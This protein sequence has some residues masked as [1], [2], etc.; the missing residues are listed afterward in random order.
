M[1]SSTTCVDNSSIDLYADQCASEA[2]GGSVTVGK[3]LPPVSW[4][5]LTRRYFWIL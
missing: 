5:S 1:S 2:L 3:H 4:Q